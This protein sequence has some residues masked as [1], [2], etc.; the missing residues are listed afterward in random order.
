M[1]KN[2]LATAM[3]G[4]AKKG[5]GMPKGA[6]KAMKSLGSLRGKMAR[7]KEQAAEGLGYAVCTLET[8]GGAFVGSLAEGY[9]GNDS[10]K[11]LGADL[12]LWGGGVM[13]VGGMADHFAGKGHMA[14]HLIATGN[15]L[16]A[17]KTASFGVEVGQT[18]RQKRDSNVVPAVPA[19]APNQPQ[20]PAAAGMDR[21]VALS[22]A[23]GRRAP[24]ARRWGNRR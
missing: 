15:G 24:V 18:M 6:K 10:L 9:Y 17:S 12:R 1:A 4:G 19:A 7:A 21:E 16:L 3:S 22:P 11:K 13:I 20:L 14:S 23:P 5:G 2:A 8:Q